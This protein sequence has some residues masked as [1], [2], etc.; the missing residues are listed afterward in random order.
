M[1]IL[2]LSTQYKVRQ[3]SQCRGDTKFYCNTCKRDLCFQCKA[4]HGIDLDIKHHDVEIGHEKFRYLP[5]Q[6]SA[7]LYD[8]RKKQVGNEQVKLTSSPVLHTS[9]C[10][11]GVSCVFHISRVMSDRVWVSGRNNLILTDTTGVTIHDLRDIT[12]LYIGGIHTVNSSG[13][14]IYIDRDGNIKKLS[15]SNKIVTTLLERTLP[16]V[17]QCVYFSSAT[18]DLVVGMCNMGTGKVTRYN[19]IGQHIL[20]IEH[21]NRGHT[22]YHIL[23][24]IT[25]NKNGDIIVSEWINYNR[26]AVVVTE[27]GGRHRFSYTGPPSR[28]PLIPLGICTDALSH[29]LVCDLNTDTVQMIDKDGHFL[30]LLLTQ[31]HRIY[32]PY[33]LDYDDKTHL[34]W[35]GSWDTNTVSVFRHIQRRYSLTDNSVDDDKIFKSTDDMK[36]GDG[37][38]K[39]S[40]SKFILPLFGLSRKAKKDKN[41]ISAASKLTPDDSF[42]DKSIDEM[43]KN[44]LPATEDLSF[45]EESYTEWILSLSGKR[46]SEEIS[47]EVGTRLTKDDPF[48]DYSKISVSTD[49]TKNWITATE[50]FSSFDDTDDSLC[51]DEKIFRSTYDKKI[52]EDT[53]KKLNSM[54]ISSL[55]GKE[56]KD[57]NPVSAGNNFSSGKT[58]KYMSTMAKTLMTKR[59]ERLKENGEADIRI[60]LSVNSLDI[61]TQSRKLGRSQII[62]KDYG[63]ILGSLDYLDCVGLSLEDKVRQSMAI[64][65]FLQSIERFSECNVQDFI[66]WMKNCRKVLRKTRSTTWGSISSILFA[67]YTKGAILEFKEKNLVEIIDHSIRCAIE[68][69]N[70]ILISE[71]VR[72]YFYNHDIQL[73]RMFEDMKGISP[74]IIDTILQTVRNLILRKLPTRQNNAIVLSFCVKCEQENNLVMIMSYKGDIEMKDRIPDKV[75]GLKLV[76]YNFTHPSDEAS[77][78]FKSIPVSKKSPLPTVTESE[79]RELFRRHSNLTMISASPYKSMGY[80]KG[81]HRVVEKLCIGLF[82]FHKGYIPYGE[83]RFPKQ[84]GEFEVDVQEGY[85]VLGSGASL[86]IGGY[87]C[88]AGCGSIGGFV[89]LPNNKTGLITCAHV[90]FS[91]KELEELE[92]MNGIPPGIEAK[93]F[94]RTAHTYKVCGTC[95]AAEFPKSFQ[96]ATPPQPNVDAVLIELDPV[97]DTFRLRTVSS[98]QLY[99]AVL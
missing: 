36:S 37:T 53:S 91:S 7:L 63:E 45:G 67:V 83:E 82:C 1:D 11:T 9:F 27:R 24:H 62:N 55:C 25:E 4:R 84:L 57:K 8:R 23:L 74:A 2:G 15:V 81:K 10:V 56:K 92:S 52:C 97:I 58:K 14:L 46:K 79:A 47:V 68:S 99:S 35:V 21:G 54:F 95:V 66:E 69:E 6:R 77:S 17:P 98:D 39:T 48:S 65:P 85:C 44:L 13:E 49:D 12:S 96:Q 5:K 87:I 33:S 3:C 71:L 94:D 42:S 28:P 88:R 78:V 60:S 72:V 40:E 61:E 93:A 50:D 59:R 51:D 32:P 19:S 70:C 75:M 89:D 16:W 43:M 30:S 20:T 29:I 80:S 31:K 76:L 18:G 34:L 73:Q 86:E 41:P 90:I 26:G 38:S 64:N 22:L